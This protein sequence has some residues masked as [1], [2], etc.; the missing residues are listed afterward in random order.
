MGPWDNEEITH[1][2]DLYRHQIE[3]FGDDHIDFK[4]NP[5]Y[6]NLS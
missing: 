2:I 6:L 3:D 5:S 4:V 1:L